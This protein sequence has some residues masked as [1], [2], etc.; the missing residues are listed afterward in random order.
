MWMTAEIRYACTTLHLRTNRPNTINTLVVYRT[1]LVPDPLFTSFGELKIELIFCRRCIWCSIQCITFL[2]W[3]SFRSSPMED[4]QLHWMPLQMMHRSVD[5]S[6]LRK[7]RYNSKRVAEMV[8]FR[9]FWFSCLAKKTRFFS[10]LRLVSLNIQKNWWNGK[11]K[12]KKD[13]L[14]KIWWCTKCRGN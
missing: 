10:M 12:A 5:F 3:F 2:Q 1:Q 6:I 4:F 7:R 8:V 14:L 11:K 9:L 13:P